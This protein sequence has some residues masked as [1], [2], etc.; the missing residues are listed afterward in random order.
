MQRDSGINGFSLF[1]T[2]QQ[3]QVNTHTSKISAAAGFGGGLA[4]IQNFEDDEDQQFLSD[5]AAKN[6][7]RS[8]DE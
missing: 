3:Q 5:L 4:K 7:L 1:N 2:I 6:Y 8:E